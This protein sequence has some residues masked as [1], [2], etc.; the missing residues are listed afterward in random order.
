MNWQNKIIVDNAEKKNISP[1]RFFLMQVA[2]DWE[3]LCM[4]AIVTNE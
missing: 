4:F 3:N 1:Y 2:D